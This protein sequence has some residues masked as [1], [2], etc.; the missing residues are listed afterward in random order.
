MLLPD[1]TSVNTLMGADLLQSH[2]LAGHV[3][4]TGADAG[5]A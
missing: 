5:I 3:L 1:M 2:G 4:V